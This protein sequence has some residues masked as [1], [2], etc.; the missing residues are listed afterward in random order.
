MKK[1]IFL[2]LL[3]TAVCT[4]LSLTSCSDDDND[5][6]IPS[7]PTPKY[8]SS[9]AK[10]EL[11]AGSPY[12]SIE[13]TASGNYIIMDSDNSS[14][15]NSLT[16]SAGQKHTAPTLAKRGFLKASPSVSRTDFNGIEYGTYTK[17]G[18]N[19]YDLQD[20]GTITVNNID[21]NTCILTISR[22]SEPTVSLPATKAAEFDDSDRT[23]ALCRTWNAD[24]VKIEVWIDEKKTVDKTLPASS[25]NWDIMEEWDN[26][27]TYLDIENPRQVI[28]S[29][30][31]TY[32]VLK[33]SQSGRRY[34]EVASWRWENENRGIL[35]Y[36]WNPD[37]FY[38]YDSGLIDIS[39]SG[40]DMTI[41]EEYDSKYDEEYEDDHFRERLTW[42]FS[43]AD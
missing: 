6:D 17:I 35:R 33:I 29:K 7:L 34:I 9:S 13:L 16:K 39:F 10:Y 24:R 19:Q 30:T 11:S 36:T 18:E 42:Y 4:G 12:S 15:Y 2:T 3:T 20:F 27:L 40:N 32:M 14:Y 28:F 25:L 38:D 21:G 37:D 22:I 31:G 43:S 41:S 23:N 8:E 5:G 26:Y 1:A